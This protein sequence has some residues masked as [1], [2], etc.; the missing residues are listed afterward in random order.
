MSRGCRSLAS[1]CYINNVLVLKVDLEEFEMRLFRQGTHLRPPVMDSQS[2]C[3]F[4]QLTGLQ[5]SH[6]LCDLHQSITWT[7][8]HIWN[9]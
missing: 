1:P 2:N 6:M 4:A 8:A 9:I 7:C 3:V 5:V